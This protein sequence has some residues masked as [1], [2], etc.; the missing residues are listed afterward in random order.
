VM[1]AAA[2]VY[3]LRDAEKPVALA[4]EPEGEI[5]HSRVYGALATERDN[6]MEVGDRMVSEGWG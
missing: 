5:T 4:E 6:S 2:A 3:F 1:A